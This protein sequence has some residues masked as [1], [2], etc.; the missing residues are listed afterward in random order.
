MNILPLFANIIIQRDVSE[1]KTESGIYLTNTDDADK[2]TVIAIGPDVKAVKV[3]DVILVNWQ[4]V[5][6][7]KDNIHKVLEEDVVGIF[8]D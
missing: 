2:A 6:I 3:G 4:K 1:L 7:I 5:P 8:Q